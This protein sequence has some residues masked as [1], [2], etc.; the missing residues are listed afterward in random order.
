MLL[1]NLINVYVFYPL[2]ATPFLSWSNMVFT[3]EKK[4]KEILQSVLSFDWVIVTRCG[5]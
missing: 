3:E 2:F 5:V 1:Q 4:L